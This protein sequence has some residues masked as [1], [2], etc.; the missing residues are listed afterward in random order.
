[1]NFYEK[2]K[3]QR[4]EDERN[5][6]RESSQRT[7]DGADGRKRSRSRSKNKQ[8]TQAEELLALADGQDYFHA[9]DGRAFA[10]VVAEVDGQDHQETLP[11]RGKDFR[12][13]LGRR[14]FLKTKKAPSS[15]MLQDVLGVLE[16]RAR[17]EGG[18]RQVCCRVGECAGK[19]YLDLAD[20][21]WRVVEI[22]P[23]G[24]R[25][26]GLSPVRFRRPRGM[27]ALPEPQAGGDIKELQQ[28]L[29]L[30]RDKDD[31][32]LVLGWLAQSLFPFG[33]YPVLCLH[34]EQGSA[35]STAS[36][37]LR[38]M[39]D[40]STAPLRS[41]PR[42]ERDLIIAAGNS[43]LFTLDN[44]SV[45]DGWLSDALC[46]LATGGGFSTRELYSDAEEVIFDAQRP[47]LLNGI[48]ELS[49]RPDLL[50]RAIVLQLPGL[51]DD[52][53][54]PER[55]FWARFE[56]A[57]PRILGALLDALA[58]ALR[59]REQVR[60]ERLPRM[61]DFAILAEAVSQSLGWK[62]G[63]F[64]DAYE[65]NRDEQ[66]RAALEGSILYEPLKALM[67][68][69]A[70]WEGTCSAL[71]GCLAGLVDD[72]T[73]KSRAWPKKP[74]VLSGM[75]RRLTSNLRRAGIRV[76]FGERS[77]DRNRDRL[78][79]VELE[80]E[81]KTPSA[82]SATPDAWDFPEPEADDERTQDRPRPSGATSSENHSSDDAD[83]ADGEKYS[84]SEADAH[85]DA[86]EG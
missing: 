10:L 63:A 53:R 67:Q 77:A 51:Q 47:V 76:T 9:P 3:K 49:S 23:D 39:V 58:G 41:L 26:R 42:D 66:D 11:V 50:D 22:G 61:A 18:Q 85:G 57:R 75:L 32:L 80:R 86:W 12:S 84:R 65:L 36:R 29:N 34:G 56:E 27:Q 33:P 44:L 74:R 13:W 8:P 60:F 68:Q 46:R 73:V 79:R 70:C 21:K 1:M 6:R 31:W 52:K 59:L 64:L 20:R 7:A 55:V 62:A 83:D 37:V 4:A 43:W 78:V 25:V 71:L 35:K 14:Y 54:Q 24:W 16:A 30:D 69:Q 5:G 17:Y 19:V 38:S 72:K 40:P 45:I 81:G 28:F 2:A 82:S 48:E 15:G